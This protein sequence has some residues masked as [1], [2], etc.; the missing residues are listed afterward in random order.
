MTLGIDIG[1]TT[2][3]L[4]LVDG[5]R[6]LKKQQVPSFSQGATLNETL[7]Y[8]ADR[9]EHFL[10]PGV[11][12]IGIGVPS[13][14]DVKRGIVYDTVNIPSWTEVPLKELLLRGVLRSP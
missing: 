8:L 11:A 3:N 6:I 5:P 10:I 14:V 9:I 2:I 13:V 1:G 7:S 4:G 12:K